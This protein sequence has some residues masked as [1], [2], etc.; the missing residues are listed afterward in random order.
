MCKERSRGPKIKR[1][2][3]KKR[4]TLATPIENDP[5]CIIEG[6]NYIND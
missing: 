3:T 5:P 6:D 4:R 2:N 1:K